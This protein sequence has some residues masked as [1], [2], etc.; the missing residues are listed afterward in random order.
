MLTIDTTKEKLR[1]REAVAKHLENTPDF[2]VRSG[3]EKM[4]DAI[5][6][7]WKGKKVDVLGGYKNVFFPILY[8]ISNEYFVTNLMFWLS[9]GLH[10]SL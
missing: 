9:Q 3:T 1:F 7:E 5:K 6:N 8:L 2:Q 4:N 10:V